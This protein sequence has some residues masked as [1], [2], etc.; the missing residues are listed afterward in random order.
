MPIGLLAFFFCNAVVVDPDYLKE[1][2]AK[3]RSQPANFDFIGL[4][5][6]ATTMVSW[7]I[8]LSKGQEWD[9]FG[10]SVFPRADASHPFC[11]RP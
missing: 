1:Q 5:L 4:C 10:R 7:E 2:R 6:L 9:W 3:M 11:R 8:V